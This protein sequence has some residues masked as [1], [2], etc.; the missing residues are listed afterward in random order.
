MQGVLAF[1]GGWLV[2]QSIAGI[3]NYFYDTTHP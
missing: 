1:L 3:Y 2:K